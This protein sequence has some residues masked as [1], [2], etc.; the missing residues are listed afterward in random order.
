MGYVVGSMKTT[1]AA[2]V[3]LAL[4][5]AAPALAHHSQS[6]FDRDS[7]MTLQ[8]EVSRYEWRNPHVYIYIRVGA[9]EPV[10]WELEGDPTP[11]MS[12]NGWAPDTLAPGDAVTFRAHPDRD[13]KKNRALLISL[14][15]TDGVVLTPR[16][17]GGASSARA[18]DISGVWDGLRGF[19]TR[20][21]VFAGLTPKAIATQAAYDESQN[22]VRDCRAYATPGLITLPYLHE[23]EVQADRIVMRTEFFKVGRT[24]YMDGRGHPPNGE[25]T[26][27]G[28]SIGRWEGEVLVVDTVLFADH[29]AGLRPGLPSSAGKHVVER[30]AL[31]EDRTRLLI[32]FIVEDTE[33]LAEPMTVAMEWDYAPGRKLL[34]FDCEPENARQFA[35]E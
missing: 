18:A 23:I 12:R 30:F 11:L 13:R 25:R 19:T 14:T 21:F 8:G 7:V 24:I 32:D 9:A 29:P 6:S 4:L 2:T 31:S 26:N 5:G 15:T 35:I 1:F 22:P 3:A 27:Q 10:E 16:G 34:S 28:H 33:Y 17:S 20:R